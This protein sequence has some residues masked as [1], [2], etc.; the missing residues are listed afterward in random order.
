MFLDVLGRFGVV[1]GVFWD[2]F[3]CFGTFWDVLKRFRTFCYVL[4]VLGGV[5]SMF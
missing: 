1:L 3:G 5:V 4:G 2:I